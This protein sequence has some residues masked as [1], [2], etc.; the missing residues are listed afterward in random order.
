MAFLRTSDNTLETRGRDNF[1]S[2]PPPGARRFRRPLPKTIV[3][4]LALGQQCPLYPQER[5]C[6]VH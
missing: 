4:Q 1:L 5:T 3:W 2:T 6:A